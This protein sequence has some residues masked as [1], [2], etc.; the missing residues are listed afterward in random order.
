M[1]YMM[2]DDDIFYTVL[3]SNLK[4][5]LLFKEQAE[6]LD[7]LTTT[8]IILD[9]KPSVIS[10]S[11]CF[12]TPIRREILFFVNGLGYLND[13]RIR[14]WNNINEKDMIF[15]DIEEALD[16]MMSIIKTEG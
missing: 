13:V 3:D 16:Y 15:R 14:N 9:L 8:A 7:I 2:I 1:P 6:K 10:N 5:K 11:I 4:F 12:S